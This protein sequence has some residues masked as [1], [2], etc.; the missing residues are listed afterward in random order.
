VLT[1]ISEA[2][3]LVVL[4]AGAAGI[5]SVTTDVGSCRELL[6]GRRG[7]SPALGPGGDVTPLCHPS[8][9]A[10]AMA[11]LLT[12]RSWYERCSRA[13]KERVRVA[14]HKRVVDQAYRDLYTRYLS[15]EAAA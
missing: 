12:D 6:Y 2:Q 14:Y 10:H 3:P 11:H 8:A 5:P 9:T 4:E 1:S 13:I 15:S 7:E